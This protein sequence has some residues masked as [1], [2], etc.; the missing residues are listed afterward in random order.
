M[1]DTVPAAASDVVGQAQDALTGETT[2]I[3]EMTDALG[4]AGHTPML[5]LPAL[6]V[7]SP[8]SGVPGFT[9]VSGVLIA[10]VS[11]QQVLRRPTLWLPRW[12]RR[13]RLRTARIRAV[14]TWFRRPARWLDS[15]TRRRLH[16]LVTP[17]LSV[18]PQGLCFALG[19]VMPL[20]ELVPFTSS[21]LGAV[22]TV[23]ATGL[24]IG[25]GLIV[26]AGMAAALALGSGLLAVF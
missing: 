8:L 2:S 19:A 26:A 23:I 20:L 4:T 25:D 21:I 22:I 7:V 5:I 6:A 15:V 10:A 18:L 24:F 9:S 13:M 16:P 12:L 11:L 1:S 17:P 3:G 14:I